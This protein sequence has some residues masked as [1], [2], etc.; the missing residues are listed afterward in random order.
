MLSIDHYD[1]FTHSFEE[2]EY[3]GQKWGLDRIE[4]V[5]EKLGSP[6]KK[7]PS[8]HIGGTNGKGSTAALVAAVLRRSGYRVGLYTSPHLEDF[9]ERIIINGE[10]IVPDRVMELARMIGQTE[11]E[12][13]EG[14]TFFEYATAMA[15]LYFASEKIDIAVVEVGLG[16]RL[17]ATN[18]LTPLVSAVTSIGKDHTALLGTHLEDIACE[19]A[20]I[21]KKNIPF[22][23][24]SFG[25]L[26]DGVL[27]VFRERASAQGAPFIPLIQNLIPPDVR[28]GL[29]GDHQIRNANT[30]LGILT[31]LREVYGWRLEASAIWEGFRS[32]Q[33]PG[34]LET[35]STRPCVLLDGAHNPDAMIVLCDYLKTFLQG[36]RLKV[37]FGA[38]R[39]KDT[40]SLIRLLKPLAA[41]WSFT[42]P[43]V[44]RAARPE[45]LQSLAS[46]LEVKSR[47]FASTASA[48]E[49]WVST[50]ED[51]EVLLVTGSLMLV[52][53]ART[54]W[55]KHAS[56]GGI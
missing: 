34:R 25:F 9:C 10:R 15:F 24:G 42:A 14:L 3:S 55:T 5:L 19:K 8:I 38:M 23:L 40:A 22:V 26:P 32:V 46:G 1:S 43:V 45:E 29:A 16:G 27:E 31:V 56:S 6:H 51:D 7:F 39:D 33:W 30:A 20:G 4:H 47:V 35:L 54:W 13:P 52:G 17:D 53:E 36:R 28:L 11:T 18:V 2:K 48:L 50:L 12:E 44:S 37:L 21:I 41:E 49:K